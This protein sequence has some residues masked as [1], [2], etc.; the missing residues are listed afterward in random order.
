[1]DMSDQYYREGETHN[2]K[3]R[4]EKEKVVS[5]YWCK[6]KTFT[7]TRRHGHDKKWLVG[8]SNEVVR[9]KLF[10]FWIS[11]TITVYPLLANL[12]RWVRVQ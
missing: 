1:M 7:S 3:N 4:S 5:K 10:H 8:E 11:Y 9:E 6:I 12:G 2:R